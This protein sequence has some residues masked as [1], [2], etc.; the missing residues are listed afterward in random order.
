MTCQDV[1]GMASIV[2]TLEETCTPPY[3]EIEHKIDHLD[4]KMDV[5]MAKIAKECGGGTESSTTNSYDFTDYFYKITW[6]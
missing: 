1:D 4:K 3:E 6:N 5:M 2:T